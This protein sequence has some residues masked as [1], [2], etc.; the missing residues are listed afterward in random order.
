MSCMKNIKYFEFQCN[1]ALFVQRTTESNNYNM[2]CRMVMPSCWC[3]LQAI[4]PLLSLTACRACWLACHVLTVMCSKDT[5]QHKIEFTWRHEFVMANYIKSLVSDRDG[6]VYV[7]RHHYFHHWLPTG[8]PS[9]LAKTR[10]R[11]KLTKILARKGSAICSYR[12]L[13]KW[14]HCSR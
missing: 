14:F 1:Y 12:F 3:D 5:T 2:P 4:V 13:L 9:L 7:V 6:T 8:R 10:R 11:F